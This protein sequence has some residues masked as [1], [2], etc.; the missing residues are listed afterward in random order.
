M[1]RRRRKKPRIKFGLRNYRNTKYIKQKLIQAYDDLPPDVTYR[2]DN[3]ARLGRRV[4]RG[5]QKRAP[6]GSR[7][8][9]KKLASGLKNTGR[10]VNKEVVDGNLTKVFE[11]RRRRW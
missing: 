11:R 3:L 1:I 7:I 10:F 2:V 9:K 6:L 5:I 4:R 8:V